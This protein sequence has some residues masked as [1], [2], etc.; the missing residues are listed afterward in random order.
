MHGRKV[1]SRYQIDSF[2]CALS[3]VS[4]SHFVSSLSRPKQPLRT[5]R[6]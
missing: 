5:V 2:I 1:L 6:A 3:L 4:L